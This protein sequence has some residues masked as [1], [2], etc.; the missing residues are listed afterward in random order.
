MEISPTTEQRDYTGKSSKKF[1]RNLSHLLGDLFG[2]ELTAASQ[3]HRQKSLLVANL[4]TMRQGFRNRL[5]QV[6]SF[7]MKS[8]RHPRF[9]HFGELMQFQTRNRII[10][11]FTGFIAHF[12]AVFFC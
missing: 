5:G 3:A 10:A 11:C 12:H 9:Y 7:Q 4:V 2:G 8:F 6:R 1:F